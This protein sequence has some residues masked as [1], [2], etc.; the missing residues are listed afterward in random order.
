[1]SDIEEQLID[2]QT[3]VAYQEDTLAQLNEV[4]TKQD[5]EIVQLKQ[6]VRLLAQRVD[7]LVR[8]PAQGDTTEIINDRPPHY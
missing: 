6:Q 3:R 1:M 2:V 5:A 4:I 7:E 8:D